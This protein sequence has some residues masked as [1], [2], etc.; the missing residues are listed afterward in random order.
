MC[1]SDLSAEMLKLVRLLLDETGQVSNTAVMELVRNPEQDY[2]HN[3][4]MKNLL[5]EKTNILLKSILQ[6][7]DDLIMADKSERDKRVRLYSI[8]REFFA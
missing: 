6:L 1:S 4:R 8:R 2:S 7:D 3:I 5:V